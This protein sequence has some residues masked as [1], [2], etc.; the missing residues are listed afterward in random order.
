V[1]VLCIDDA[2]RA[3]SGAI[4]SHGDV[5][6]ERHIARRLGS[7]VTKLVDVPF[8]TDLHLRLL[9][10]LDRGHN[11]RR[12][13]E[14]AVRPG[15]RVLDAG[16]GSGL[17]SLIALAAGAG[18]AVGF[19]RQHI[20]MARTIAEKNG[21]A[22]RITL[23][24]ADLMDLELS[25]V[26]LGRRF[27]VLFAFIYTNHPLVDETRS[28]MVFELR[29]RFGTA[30]C[31]IVPGAVRYRATGCDRLDW[32]LHT[33]LTDL[34]DAADTLRACYGLD[35]QPLVEAAKQELPVKRSRPTDPAASTWRPPTTM[36]SVR[37]PRGD[38]RLL[39]DPQQ[40]VE[41][42]YAAPEFRGIPATVPLRVVSPGRLS[43]VIWTQELLYAGE[44]VW[45]TE[46]YAPLATP[47]LTGAGDELTV[48]TGDEWRATNVLRATVRRGAV[49]PAGA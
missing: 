2:S 27:D 6:G 39:T 26:D 40:V 29:D 36:A 35:F 12:A 47:L 15:D 30:D 21:L 18:E 9:L 46:T 33:E 10:S 20:E 13:V 4:D 32:D 19:D 38:V 48:H 22:D 24:Q 43:G 16:T 1:P 44:P 28:R 42:D 23:L 34:D 25:G 5:C 14:A 17:L 8:T 31:R 37:F 11:V 41:I 7:F 49:G 3:Q 45:T